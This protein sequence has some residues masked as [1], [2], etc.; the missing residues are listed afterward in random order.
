MASATSKPGRT[1]VGRCCAVLGVLL[2]V[3]TTSVRGDE[4]NGR[5]FEQL[6]QRR[7]F[8]L[9]EGECYRHLSVDDLPL[10]RRTFYVL[11]LS[12]TLAEH[13]R[14][15]PQADADELWANARTV[16]DELI[17]REPHNPER[18]LLQGRMLLIPVRRAEHVRRQFD[19]A[20]YDAAKKHA[21]LRLFAQCLPP[22]EAFEKELIEQ[23]KTRAGKGARDEDLSDLTLSSL[24]EDVQFQLSG[25][26]ISHAA[27]LSNDDPK[28]RTTLD[29]ARPLLIRMAR[30]NR[31]DERSW[32][33]KILL[34]ASERLR[35]DFKKAESLLV[36][37]ERAEPALAISD[38]VLA[39]RMRLRLLQDRPLEA[40][41][42]LL[43]R[44]KLSPALSSELHYLNAAA[45]L[46]MWKVAADKKQLTLADEIMQKIEADV[47]RAERT[48]G[49]YWLQRS[50]ELLD[51]ARTS[52][53]YGEEL[54]MLMKRAAALFAAGERGEA[55]R[56]YGEA[57]TAAHRSK[58]RDLAFELGYTRGSILFQHR[59]FEDGAQAFLELAEH[60]TNHARAHNAH[61]LAV[62]CLGKAYDQQRTRRRREAYTDALQEHRRMF[63]DRETF[64]EASWLL[65]R[66]HEQRRQAT[67]ALPLYAEIPLNSAR[68]RAAQLGVARCYEQVLWYLRNEAETPDPAAINRWHNEA[69][70]A[71]GVMRDAF[72]DEPKTFDV[73]QVEIVLRL[74]RIRLGHAPVDYQQVDALLEVVIRAAAAQRDTEDSELSGSTPDAR[75]ARWEWLLQSATQLRVISLAG[76]KRLD[77][78]HRLVR[79][80]TTTSPTDLL[81]ILDGLTQL[82]ETVDPRQR[83][84]LGLLQLDAAGAL[85]ERRAEL[86]DSQQ[87]R[88]D[89]CRAQAYAATNQPKP[90]IVIYE[91]LVKR[92][93][94]DRNLIR[95]LAELQVECG[96]PPYLKG[97]LANWQ[98]LETFEKRGT[99]SWLEIRY[100][101]AQV[102]FLRKE[103]AAAKKILGVGRLLYPELGSP[104]LKKRWLRLEADVKKAAE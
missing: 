43:E 41:E 7:L 2:G 37:I 59:K 51:L 9:I 85:Y 46:E 80:L 55:V 67:Q 57:T 17:Q 56:V 26:I 102:R 104:T 95:T 98:R 79:R 63:A 61:L 100:Q 12:Q 60:Y 93:P 10:P 16:L 68:G 33:S 20:P 6:R 8:A 77:E 28:R 78:A 96:T 47:A 40:S 39:E 70:R 71:L 53:K 25:A 27:L 86:T 15:V 64:A 32:Q 90:A 21:A 88:L 97:A 30:G 103:Y 23:L 19:L 87:D 81:G 50:R 35:G 62:F 48:A 5:F 72:G 84:E 73:D 94:D 89:R 69:L 74:A 45:L 38:R 44:R 52:Q 83:S 3:L 31:D 4:I 66:F 1:R 76:Q 75:R 91:Q 49:G 34:A 42:L 29:G 18:I 24:H 54:A 14:F 65:A 11:Q 82:A 36:T 13:A 99:R 22:L 92:F 58:H 101:T